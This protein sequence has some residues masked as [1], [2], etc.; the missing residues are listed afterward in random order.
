MSEDNKSHV[1]LQQPETICMITMA[2]SKKNLWK[3][4]PNYIYLWDCRGDSTNTVSGNQ[5]VNSGQTKTKHNKND[6]S[7]GLSKTMVNKFLL[8]MSSHGCHSSK[9]Q[10]LQWHPLHYF[11]VHAVWSLILP[12]YDWVLTEYFLI[13]GRAHILVLWELEYNNTQHYYD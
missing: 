1:V 3:T 7:L 5:H 12:G 13:I 9:A 10:A 2:A 4:F 6:H 11:L 8:L